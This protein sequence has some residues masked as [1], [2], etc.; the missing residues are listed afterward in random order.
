MGGLEIRDKSGNW[1][2]V[3]PIEGTFVVN[4]GDTMKLWTNNRFQSTPH[5]VINTRGASRY[6]IPFFANPD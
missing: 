5:R 4:I 2:F 6:S 1:K 3:A